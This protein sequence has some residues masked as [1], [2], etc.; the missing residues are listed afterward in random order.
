M[1]REPPGRVGNRLHGA[2]LQR[3]AEARGTD[4]LGVENAYQKVRSLLVALRHDEPPPAPI[5]QQ[6]DD[7]LDLGERFVVAALGELPDR[8][9]AGVARAALEL[10]RAVDEA[11][12]LDDQGV[13]AD[14]IAIFIAVCDAGRAAYV[15]AGYEAS[16]FV[17]ANTLLLARMASDDFPAYR[18]LLNSHRDLR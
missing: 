13:T 14:D 18:A 4:R 12:R 5:R 17:G 1:L 16:A 8:Y 7:L 15:E 3:V 2:A 11:V 9:L 10:R 6:I